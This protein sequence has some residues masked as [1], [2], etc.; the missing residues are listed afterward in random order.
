MLKVNH[1]SF[2]YTKNKT[3]LQNI[4]FRLKAGEHLSIM[5]ASGCGKSTLLKAIYGLL[6]LNEGSIFW[7]D[8]EILGP[9]FNLVPGFYKF[10]YVK[11]KCVFYKSI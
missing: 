3:V 11:E 7:N 5:G 6:D 8:E 2:A 9:E 4:N 10:K 1:L